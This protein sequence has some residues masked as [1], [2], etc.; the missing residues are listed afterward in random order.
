MITGKMVKVRF[1]KYFADQKVWVF[2]GKVLDFTESWVTVEGK[3]VVIFKGRPDPV[4][5]DEEPR[6]LVIPRENIARIRILPDNFDISDIRT[7]EKR[8]RMY[9]VVDGGPDTSISE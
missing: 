5:I 8:F 6:V 7:E 4:D 1:R 3:A 2:I 9:V